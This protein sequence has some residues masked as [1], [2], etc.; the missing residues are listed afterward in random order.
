VF[1]SIAVHY[2]ARGI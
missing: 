2:P 1:V